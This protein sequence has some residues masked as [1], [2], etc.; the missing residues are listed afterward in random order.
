M[1]LVQDTASF[2][3]KAVFGNV[4]TPT[5]ALFP[6]LARRMSRDVKTLEMVPPVLTGTRSPENKID[7][8]LELMDVNSMNT[9]RYRAIIIED[10][11]DRQN[12][13][14]F[15]RFAHV[16]SARSIEF[17]RGGIGSRAIDAVRDALNE[18]TGIRADYEGYLT[19]DDSRMMEI[20]IISWKSTRE[21]RLSTASQR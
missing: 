13:T 5:V 14:G 21:S 3:T 19:F 8:A 12:I 17:G 10:P 2:N 7:M 11:T 6:G 18:F 15:I 9:G 16:Q 1:D 20:P 4:S